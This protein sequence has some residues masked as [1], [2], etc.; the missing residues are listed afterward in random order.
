MV[1]TPD[2]EVFILNQM[3]AQSNLISVFMMSKSSKA[4]L[5]F[6]S[7]QCIVKSVGSHYKRQSKKR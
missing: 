2:R 4:G 5:L 6:G 7:K 3:M 1:A